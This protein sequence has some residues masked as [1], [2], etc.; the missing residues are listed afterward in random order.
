MAERGVD[1]EDTAG[2]GHSDSSDDARL[3]LGEAKT[4]V[5]G[6]LVVGVISCMSSISR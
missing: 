4:I 3:R 1:G 6:E 5:D 2:L